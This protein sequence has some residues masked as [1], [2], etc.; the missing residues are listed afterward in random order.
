M[1]HGLILGMTESGKSTLAKELAAALHARGTC[2]IILDPL[3]DPGWPNGE[4]TFQTADRAQF[5]AM[6]KASR[7]CAVFVDES[8]QMIGRYAGEMEWLATQGRHW[9]HSS[10]FISQR[11][12]QLSVTMRGQ[13]RFL[14]LFR[15]SLDDGKTHANEWAR[16]ELKG[17]NELAQGE[18]FF[19]ERF[20][21]LKRYKLWK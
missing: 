16:E 12:Q 3:H 11:A 21:P 14:A 9:G 18:Y 10:F 1:G 8:A 17:A 7:S 13:C 5:L 15:C 19:C 6:V 20:G 4:R 2:I